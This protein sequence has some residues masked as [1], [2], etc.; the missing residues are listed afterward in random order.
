AQLYKMLIEGNTDLQVSTKSGLGGTKICFDALVHNQIDLY[1]EYTGT[2]FLVLL[3]PA[4][5]II[6]EL[7]K[8]ATGVYQYV[9]HEFQTQYQLKLLKP[10]GFNNT[11]ALMMRRTQA[12]SL[13]ITSISNLTHYLNQK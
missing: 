11:Y 1:P 7:S 6:E 4:K 13:R 12:Q 5:P 9:Q 10:I 8:N 3:K 2:A